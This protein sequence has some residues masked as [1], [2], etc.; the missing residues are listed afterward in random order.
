MPVL[1]IDTEDHLW[2]R[3][4]TARGVEIRLVAHATHTPSEASNVV[5]TVTGREPNLAPLVLMTPRSG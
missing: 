3:D 5:A 4:L 1:Q 2:L